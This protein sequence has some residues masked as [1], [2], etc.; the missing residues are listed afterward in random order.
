MV[1]TGLVMVWE[2]LLYVNH[3]SHCAV[4]ALLTSL[5]LLL[6][7]CLVFM[8]V[9][10]TSK[11][12]DNC[13]DFIIPQGWLWY[14]IILA[15]VLVGCHW[16]SIVGNNIGFYSQM[17]VGQIQ[18]NPGIAAQL[19]HHGKDTQPLCTSSLHK[20]GVKIPPFGSHCFY[21]PFPLRLFSALVNSPALKYS[22][23]K[24]DFS[25]CIMGRCRRGFHYTHTEQKEVSILDL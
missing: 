14:I 11:V 6:P 17:R 1:V 5:S 25:E 19:Y 16:D 18:L 15:R 9:Q 3:R 2:L 10:G 20:M 8:I 7:M 4:Q 23:R 13:L 21:P 24:V 12:Q 22:K